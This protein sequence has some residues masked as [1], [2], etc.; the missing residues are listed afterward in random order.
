[1]KLSLTC[2]LTIAF[3]LVA[4]TATIL[5]ALVM[6]LYSTEQLNQLVIDQQRD[7]LR[8]H[9]WITTSPMVHGRELE[10]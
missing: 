4:L 8:N 1:M 7:N 6:R 5:V 10:N 2:K 9:C 3:L